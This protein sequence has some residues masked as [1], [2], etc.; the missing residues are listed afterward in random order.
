[1]KMRHA[2]ALMILVAG[3]G[4][5]AVPQ[6]ASAAD[7]RAEIKARM[8][9]RL[10][11]VVALKAGGVAGENNAGQLAILGT[12][13]EADKAVVAAEN[14]DRRTVY[15]AIAARTGTTPEA[16]GAHRAKKI[17]ESAPA[18]VKIQAAGGSWTTKP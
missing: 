10:P 16:V 4:L 18:G 11:Q 1:M 8:A 7:T 2:V 6:A 3:G 5:L 12:A 14:S 13:T 9:Q 15:A 17:A